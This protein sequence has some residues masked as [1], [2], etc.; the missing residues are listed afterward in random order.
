MRE[1]KRTFAWQE[2]QGAA[3]GLVSSTPPVPVPRCRLPASAFPAVVVVLTPT[4]FH[5]LRR[6]V[7]HYLPITGTAVDGQQGLSTHRWAFMPRLWGPLPLRDPVQLSL[8]P[9]SMCATGRRVRDLDSG[10]AMYRL[11]RLTHSAPLF[12]PDNKGLSGGS[13]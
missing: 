6:W 4:I 10:E 7:L 5:L 13:N 8:G 1:P 9:V 2:M 3:G 11:R 12:A